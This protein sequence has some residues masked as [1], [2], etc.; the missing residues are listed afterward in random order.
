MHTYANV[1]LY[2]THSEI[3]IHSCLRMHDEYQEAEE[4][5]GEGR[6]R[7]APPE[8][9]LVVK[10]E[11]EMLLRRVLQRK[12]WPA[13]EVGRHVAPALHMLVVDPLEPARGVGMVEMER[14]GGMGI[15]WEGSGLELGVWSGAFIEG[16]GMVAVESGERSCQD[17]HNSVFLPPFRENTASRLVA[18]VTQRFL[19]T[20]LGRQAMS[21]PVSPLVLVQGGACTGKSVLLASAVE[22]LRHGLTRGSENWVVSVVM[23]PGGQQCGAEAEAFGRAACGPSAA[24]RWDLSWALQYLARDIQSQIRP[25]GGSGGERKVASTIG[26]DL[27]GAWRWRGGQGEWGAQSVQKQTKAVAVGFFVEAI[28]AAISGRQSGSRAGYSVVCV[29]DG[30]TDAEVEEL[31]ALVE[32][33]QEEVLVALVKILGA[34]GRDVAPVLRF[35]ASCQSLPRSLAR[36]KRLVPRPA[37]GLSSDQEREG[38]TDADSASFTYRGLVP[39]V[40]L[41]PMAPLEIVSLACSCLARSSNSGFPFVRDSARGPGCCTATTVRPSRKHVEGVLEKVLSRHQAPRKA[42]GEQED[43]EVEAKTVQ[44]V[45]EGDPLYVAVACHLSIMFDEDEAIRARLQELPAALPDAFAQGILQPLEV[46]HGRDIVQ[47]LLLQLLAAPLGVNR[48]DLKHILSHELAPLASPSWLP[49]ADIAVDC[50][51]SALEPM[52]QVRVEAPCPI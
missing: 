10:E 3:L 14:D 20:W 32:R 40:E 22:G 2:L 46:S 27:V 33:I 17:G 43:A 28:V 30:L 50:I 23:V 45:I 36:L 49:A 26:A 9:F 34:G 38:T 13:A 29:V 1:K 11:Q 52:L 19:P 8:S 5:E 51:L 42:R 31:H 15:R 39:V 7:K 6:A 25:R 4:K 24:G 44:Q 18:M 41:G 48:A 35:V 16:G 12:A 21:K 37:Q 47:A